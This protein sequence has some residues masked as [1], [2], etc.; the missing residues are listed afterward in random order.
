[1]FAVIE[2]TPLAS[3]IFRIKIRCPL[4]PVHYRPGQFAVI[5]T[6]EKS[7][8]IP[9]TIVEAEGD[10]ITLIYQVVGRSTEKLSLVPA[11]GSVFAV[12]GPLG[13][14]TD[15]KKTG[16][17]VC[18]GGG[19]GSA[20]LYPE[21][22]AHTIAGNRVISIIGARSKDLLILVPEIRELSRE[23]ILVTDDGSAG[24]KGLVTMP[25]ERILKSGKP[26]LVIAI[27][28]VVMMKAVSEL[29]RPYGVKTVVSL[30]PIMVDATGMCGACRV[31]VGGKT[32]FAC[33]D[34]P[35]FDGHKVDFE[36]L[37]LRNRQYVSLEKE[38]CQCRK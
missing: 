36:N 25:L 26:D 32:R 12:L 34:G 17:V 22:K 10:I 28:P 33:V 19:V 31:T 37:L 27:G 14:A 7:E 24:E 38:A 13:K 35:E 21:V 9:L 29:T 8:R 4:I 6:D 5:M 1:M 18:I 30:N 20:V 23:C 16:K 15:I 3:G 11:G 2:N